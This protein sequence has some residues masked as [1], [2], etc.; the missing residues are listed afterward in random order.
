MKVWVSKYALSIG[1]KRIDVEKP[2]SGDL[3]V[4]ESGEER[5]VFRSYRLGNHAHKTR[6]AAEAAAEKMRTR[7]ISSLKKRIEKLEGLSFAK[8]E[9]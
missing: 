3:Y 7:A 8:A 1:L 5:G 9:A 6:E 2:D 4:Y